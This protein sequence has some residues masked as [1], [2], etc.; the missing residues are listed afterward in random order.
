MTANQFRKLALALPEATEGE[1]MNHPDFRVAGKIFATVWPDDRWGVVKLT[2]EEQ[3][4]VCASEPSVYQPVQGGWGRAGAT[5][6]CF[7]RRQ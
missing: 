1:H 5:K 4:T 7:K 2:V 6:V 3:S